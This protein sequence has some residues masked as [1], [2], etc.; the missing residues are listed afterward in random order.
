MPETESLSGKVGLDVTDFKNG[1]VEMQREIKVIE[2]GF[3]ASAAALG[4]WANKASGLET[5]IKALNSEISIQ[6]K[7]VD[8]NVQVY[9]RLVASYGEGSRAAEEQAITVN[10]STERLNKMQAELEQDQSALKTVATSS[11]Q[12]STGIEQVGDKAQQTDRKML[13][14]K[15]VAAGLKTAMGGVVTVARD[16]AVAI[17]AVAGAAIAVGTAVGGM[18]SK[19]ADASEALMQLHEKTGMSLEKLQEMQYVAAGLGMNLE[20]VTDPMSKLIRNMGL[21]QKSTSAQ[22]KEFKELNVPIKDAKGNLLDAN[23]VF[24]NTI[25]AL[26]KMPNK[27]QADVLAMD[28]FGK[29]A[30]ELNPL[31]DAT[32]QKIN[33][34]V[35]KSHTNGAIISDK[36]IQQASDL[37]R[38]AGL[39]KLS[40]G[41]V[42]DT[43]LAGIIPG[44]SDGMS[45]VQDFI[46]RFK[47]ISQM[48]GD[49]AG[50]KN[51]LMTGLIGDIGTSATQMMGAGVSLLQGL[52]QGLI[53]ALPALLPGVIQII[54]GLI[55]FIIQEFP[56]LL[57]AGEQLLTQLMQGIETA[58]PM[59]MPVVTEVLNGLTSFLVTSLP[60][61]LSAGILLLTT[62]SNGITQALPTMIPALTNL[63]I[64]LVNIL[65]QNLPLLLN[66]GLQLLEALLKGIEAALPM[67]LSQ[68]PLIMKA[69]VDAL[70][71]FLPMLG[72]V[73]V[74]IVMTL[75]NGIIG[76]LPTLGAVLPQ[77]V[78][79]LVTAQTSVAK[80]LAKIGINI[81][82][83]IWQGILSEKAKF[84][85]DITNFFTNIV[86]KV[87]GLLG[88]NSPSKIFAG[89]GSSM[90]EGIDVGYSRQVTALQRKIT[91]SV[92]GIAS[93]SAY[94][95]NNAA[96]A[97]VNNSNESYA[98]YGPVIFPGAGGSNLG[99][100]VRAKRF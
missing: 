85:A 69:L 91:A 29:S 13:S 55:T 3:K 26:G 62:L 18:V 100:A 57:T 79:V 60:I 35:S 31:I 53:A 93:G 86:D 82:E 83:G 75:L 71:I 95:A 2:T 51:G 52:V 63:V 5:R 11:D 84:T 70:I 89:I 28:L 6:Q 27:T 7:V 37:D 92:G 32:G 30:L 45:K 65:I 98:F 96:S 4:D 48:G 67:I 34:L 61:L 17:A 68:M 23:T 8:A 12:A 36:D 74:Q 9:N 77:M 21:A 72:T 22:S 81:V 20:D 58:I 19:D 64:Q 78:A 94:S 49:N 88:I 24:A 76:S 47:D 15:D 33:D 43:I 59:L 39:L 40:F 46:S 56:L 90:V 80:Q 87:K 99:D 25:D 1:V 42:T 10:K 66:A 54:N 14:L 16:A 38:Q 44:I 41:G 73:A 97:T 50:V